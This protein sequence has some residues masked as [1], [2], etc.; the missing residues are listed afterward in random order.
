M[1]GVLVKR[2]RVNAQ[3]HSHEER[4]VDKKTAIDEPRREACEGASPLSPGREPGLP[5]VDPGLLASGTVREHI[6]VV[7]A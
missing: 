5:H 4:R 2:G 1:T 6:S 7:Y 3:I